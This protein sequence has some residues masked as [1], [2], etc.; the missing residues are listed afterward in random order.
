MRE[1]LPSDD[2]D[3]QCK[4]ALAGYRVENTPANLA[5]IAGTLEVFPSI[6]DFRPM[7]SSSRSDGLC[8]WQVGDK[9]ALLCLEWA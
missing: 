7:H 6:D 4:H 9:R 8:L 2:A 3:G 5:V 1:R